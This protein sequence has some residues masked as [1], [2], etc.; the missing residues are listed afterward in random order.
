MIDRRK[1]MLAGAAGMCIPLVAAYAQP[2]PDE[3]HDAAPGPDH[4]GP[5]DHRPAMPPPRHEERPRAPGPEANWRWR[6]G[7]WNWGGHGWVWVSG[8][9]FR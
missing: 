3:H 1:I 6:D 4:P 8:Q 7:H 5:A 2:A 9:W